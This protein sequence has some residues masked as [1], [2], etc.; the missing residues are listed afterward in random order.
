MSALHGRGTGDLL[1]EV[2][3]LL[4]EAEA[5]AAGEGSE[6]ARRASRGHWRS[7]APGGIGRPARTSASPRLFNRLVGDDRS[8]THDEPG[9]TRDSVDTVVETPEGAVCFIDTAG[10]RRKS[11]TERGT[12]Y[13]SVL[14]AL[15]ALDRADIALLVIDATAGVTHQDQRLAERIAAAGSPTVVVLNKWELLETE[16]RPEVLP[17]W[18]TGSP[19]SAWRRCSR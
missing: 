17:T 19:S 15:E 10:L 3:A 4:P 12:E 16:Q 14:R 1:D 18:A 9:T 7:G 2:V 13:F 6:V 5:P 8:V 11:R